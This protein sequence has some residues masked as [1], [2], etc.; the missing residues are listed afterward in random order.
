MVIQ[1]ACPRLLAKAAVDALR[2]VNVVAR[3]S[4]TTILPLLSLDSDRL[5]R[6]NLYTGEGG[7]GRM[8]RGVGEEKVLRS[9]SDASR[10]KSRTVVPC[11]RRCLNVKGGGEGGWE[12]W[13]KYAKAR[14]LEFSG[15]KS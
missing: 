11:A 4:P 5:R 8:K 2:H 7:R 6:A 1:R 14:R 15:V 3:G 9:V 10:V 13:E 12:E